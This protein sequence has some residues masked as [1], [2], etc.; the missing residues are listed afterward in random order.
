MADPDELLLKLSETNEAARYHAKATEFSKMEE[1]EILSLSTQ[2]FIYLYLTNYS[3]L[4]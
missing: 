3:M 2:K 1:L 4:D